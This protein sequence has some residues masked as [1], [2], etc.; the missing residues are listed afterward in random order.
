MQKFYVE[1]RISLESNQIPVTSVDDLINARSY[2]K[3]LFE[4]HTT[5]W[6][7]SFSE[8]EYNTQTGSKVAVVGGYLVLR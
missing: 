7:L 6:E 4:T 2:I 8:I 1:I 3:S 5:G